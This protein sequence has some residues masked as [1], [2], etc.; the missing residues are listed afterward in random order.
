MRTM[1]SASGR[2]GNAST[3]RVVLSTAR[4]R[5]EPSRIATDVPQA[6]FCGVVAAPPDAAINV[7]VFV[8]VE[9]APTC[10]DATSPHRKIPP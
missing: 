7:A 6:G 8:P 4:H 2:V 5:V 9:S 10:T 3:G 1:T